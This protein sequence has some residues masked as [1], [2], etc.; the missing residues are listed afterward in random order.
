MFAKYKIHQFVYM[1]YYFWCGVWVVSCS[2][3]V[4]FDESFAK[5]AVGSD[6]QVSPYVVVA[7]FVPTATSSSRHSG[8]SRHVHPPLFI[9]RCFISSINLDLP[10]GRR[11]MEA[12]DLSVIIIPVELWF[13]IAEYLKTQQDWLAFRSTCKFF[14]NVAEY[15][16]NRHVRINLHDAYITS[17]YIK[18]LQPQTF[19]SHRTWV[20]A[21]NYNTNRLRTN[22]KKK[23]DGL[24]AKEQDKIFSA[25][26]NIKLVRTEIATLNNLPPIVPPKKR[27]RT[28]PI[29]PK[30][31]K[32]NKRSDEQ[33]KQIQQNVTDY[34]QRWLRAQQQSNGH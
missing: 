12:V 22:R 10:V 21:S 6:Q 32:Y 16:E 7:V 28:K 34:I 15:I 1:S 24:V 2:D 3:A 18:T 33:L 26:R 4:V 11:E 29:I 19:G 27:Q 8:S 20:L 17:K 5:D 30:T 13:C 9:T 25:K 31:P 23:L 14:K